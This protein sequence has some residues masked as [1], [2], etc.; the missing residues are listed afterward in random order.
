MFVFDQQIKSSNTS[1]IER[2][3][4]GIFN[5]EMSS[6]HPSQAK[7]TSVR[8]AKSSTTGQHSATQQTS[9]LMGRRARR[10]RD[11]DDEGEVK[12][13]ERSGRHVIASSVKM[14]H[15]SE[16]QSVSSYK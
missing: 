5:I 10:N 11:S 6:E 3:R 7:T 1:F 14:S 16:A 4:Q 2:E 13:V 9:N 12:S 15:Y 8:P